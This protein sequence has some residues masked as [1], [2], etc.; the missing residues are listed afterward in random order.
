MLALR[1]DGSGLLLL[2]DPSTGRNVEATALL[3][4]AEAGNPG[5]MAAFGKQLFQLW[6]AEGRINQR[7]DGSFDWGTQD[8]FDDLNA[9]LRA[10]V[11]T[12]LRPYLNEIRDQVSPRDIDHVAW[13]RNAHGVQL[14]PID[15]AWYSPQAQVQPTV[16]VR[17]LCEPC[18]DTTGQTS[19][20]AGQCAYDC[21]GD[22]V[23]CDLITVT[24]PPQPPTM[25][26]CPYYDPDC[27]GETEIARKRPQ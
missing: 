14:A 2:T 22:C 9:L 1:P 18:A 24:P 20:P 6:L 27:Y 19:C 13:T 15:K 3:R 26:P 10:A 11:V 25:P 17:T 8:N 4:I 16:C 23:N 21:G 12:E 7:P 5:L